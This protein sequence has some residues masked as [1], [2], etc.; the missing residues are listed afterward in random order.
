MGYEVL[1]LAILL[2]VLFVGA[3][4]WKIYSDNRRELKGLTKLPVRSRKRIRD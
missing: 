1:E 4:I 2:V 3:T